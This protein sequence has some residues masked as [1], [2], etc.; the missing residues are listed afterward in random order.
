MNII[1]LGI[2]AS[3]KGTQS[4]LLAKKLNIPHVS[5][6]DIF[7]YNI[8]QRTSLGKKIEK[9]LDKGSL[10]PSRIVNEVVKQRLKEK[11]VKKGF[12][13]DGYPRTLEQA[14]FLN[15]ITNIDWAIDINVSDREAMSRLKNRRTCACGKTYNLKYNPPQKPG[16]CDKC[17]HRLFIRDDDRPKAIKERLSIYHEETKDLL[18]YYD[19][20]GI[21]ESIGGERDIKDIHK[22]IYKKLK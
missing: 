20:K 9:Y 2:Q 19:K 11:D 13:L 22:D 10:V 5:T 6:G 3:G 17:G 7:R 14:K 4:I 18:I 16:I 8:E 21:L 15:K 12:V 1:F